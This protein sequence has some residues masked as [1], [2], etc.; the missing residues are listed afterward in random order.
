MKSENKKED[1]NNKMKQDAPYFLPTVLV[2][3]EKDMEVLEKEGQMQ[4]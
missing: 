4:Q 3:M 1:S 2:L